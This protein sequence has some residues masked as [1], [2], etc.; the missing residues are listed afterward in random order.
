MSLH[1]DP[2]LWR[3]RTEGGIPYKLMEG[4]PKGS[5]GDDAATATEIYLIQASDL[6]DFVDEVMS[7][8]E[9]WPGGGWRHRPARGLPGYPAL[10]TKKVDWEPHEGGLPCDPFGA[11]EYSSWASPQE[12]PAGTYAK[13]L[14][15]TISYSTSKLDDKDQDLLEISC[16]GAG[17]FLLLPPSEAKVHDDGAP[18][19]PP[20]P[21]QIPDP[22]FPLT[23]SVPGVEWSVKY[24]R[25]PRSEMPT[26]LSLCRGMLGKV[27]NAPVPLLMATGIHTLMFMGFS[28]RAKWSWRTPTAV[29]PP[30]VD[31]LMN[32]PNLWFELDLK[33]QEKCLTK[34]GVTI[35]WNHFLTPWG[36]WE[37][38]LPTGEVGKFC[39]DAVDFS[40]L[41]SGNL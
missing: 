21:K 2:S 24:N 20:K 6:S 26:V 39:Y 38:I 25:I 30:T 40:P 36:T 13:F 16:S 3:H 18:D 22:G 4:H 1:I 29:K 23:V 9:A 14:K 35:G 12:A 34:D 32:D 5:F 8:S 27:N 10:R 17:E 31:N 28:M 37:K 7:Q 33:I 11:G 15:L 41:L 19:G